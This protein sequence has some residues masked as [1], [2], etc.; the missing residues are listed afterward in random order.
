MTEELIKI[1]K[2]PVVVG[3][4]TAQASES[5]GADEEVAEA[6]ATDGA[7]KAGATKEEEVAVA[8]IVE[9]PHNMHVVAEVVAAVEKESEV[10][11]KEH[12]V[13]TVVEIVEALGG[14]PL[15]LVDAVFHVESDMG[16]KPEE[17]VEAANDALH[18]LV[19]KTHEVID[20][21]TIGLEMDSL[22]EEVN[23]REEVRDGLAEYEAQQGIEDVDVEGEEI[24]EFMLLAYAYAQSGVD[25]APDGRC[26]QL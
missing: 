1:N 19:E 13:E 16:A 11:S 12:A 24:G 9:D 2:S 21:V 3:L 15:Q 17:A 22:L 6:A 26:H 5:A 20:P 7:N 10:P 25:S 23:V 4:S 14:T 8:A 18:D